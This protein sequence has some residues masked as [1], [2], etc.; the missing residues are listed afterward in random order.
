MMSEPRTHQMNVPEI[1][2]LLIQN[3][4]LASQ[5]TTTIP[6]LAGLKDTP[7]NMRRVLEETL[8]TLDL[9]N[10]GPAEPLPLTQIE[11]DGDLATVSYPLKQLAKAAQMVRN[12]M[13]GL[14]EPTVPEPQSQA[15][16][17]TAQ[18][19]NV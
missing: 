7:P 15:K 10:P 18:T 17:D 8:S 16:L 19:A 14:L 9:K 3:H 1:N 4:V 13:A 6:L 5:I 11:N 12:E 2:N